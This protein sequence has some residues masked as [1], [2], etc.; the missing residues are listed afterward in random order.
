[1][2]VIMGEKYFS[3]DDLTEELDAKEATLRSYNR[4]G[5]LRGVKIGGETLFPES[6]LNTFLKNRGYFQMR[7]LS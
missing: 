7:E 2:K 1:M 5:I 3:L 4:K 6:A